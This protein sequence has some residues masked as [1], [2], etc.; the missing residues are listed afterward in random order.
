MDKVAEAIYKTLGYTPSPSQQELHDSKARFKFI[1][2]GSRFGKS[3]CG[4]MDVLPD[5]LKP[6]TRGW[7]VGPSYD[8]PSKEFR[9]IYDA[10]V[11]K[12]RG[13]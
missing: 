7:I 11:G 8:Q 9:Y 12:L 2:A 1:G 10:L 4:A 6:K 5:I 13:S 3:L